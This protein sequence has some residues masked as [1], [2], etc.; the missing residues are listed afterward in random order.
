M[1]R[2]E[3]R[4][5]ALDA[6]AS[7][8]A[9]W[10]D[11]SATQANAF[12]DGSLVLQLAGH[13]RAGRDVLDGERSGDCFVVEGSSVSVADVEVRP[14][15]DDSRLERGFQ[16]TCRFQTRDLTL[17]SPSMGIRLEYGLATDAS[18]TQY[19]SNGEAW[20]VPRDG[21]GVEE[22]AA[23]AWLSATGSASA[24]SFPSGYPT[25]NARMFSWTAE[26]GVLAGTTWLAPA[27]QSS[28]GVPVPLWWLDA[29]GNVMRAEATDSDRIEPAQSVA[30]SPGRPSIVAFEGGHEL[31][32]T[33]ADGLITRFVATPDAERFEALG[34][35]ALPPLHSL[36]GAVRHPS[37]PSRLVLAVA[38]RRYGF[39]ETRPCRRSCS[40]SWSTSVLERDR[41][42]RPRGGLH[43]RTQGQEARDRVRDR[44]PRQAKRTREPS[45]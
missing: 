45:A 24:V 5:L 19:I 27:Q 40:R 13:A 12:E 1:P 3:L 30:F 7:E 39:S 43:S 35:V 38:D 36:I 26:A 20:F 25:P 9:L 23:Y 15:E 44:G 18:G 17:G 16:R 41:S 32:T 29:R 21:R 37:T 31:L 14:F 34:R 6:E 11:P 10:F 22:N 2:L 42:S 8:A 28:G 4:P 33:S